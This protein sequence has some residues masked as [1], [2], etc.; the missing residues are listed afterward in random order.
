MIIADG[1]KKGESGKEAFSGSSGDAANGNKPADIAGKF[2][3]SN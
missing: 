3:D 2:K 1:Q